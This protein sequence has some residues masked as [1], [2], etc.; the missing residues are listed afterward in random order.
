MSNL[1]YNLRRLF[2][3][4]RTKN[5]KILFFLLGKKE[6]AELEN[7]SSVERKNKTFQSVSVVAVQADS[8]LAA[9]TEVIE[10]EK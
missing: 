10:I 5:Q 2:T 3:A 8:Y 4:R 9:V 1:L 7:A 6:I